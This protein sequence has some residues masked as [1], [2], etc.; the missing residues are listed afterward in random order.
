MF[1]RMNAVR[2]IGV[3]VLVMWGFA[4]G[5]CAHFEGQSLES[6][7]ELRRQAADDRAQTAREEGYQRMSDD[8][9]NR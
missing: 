9:A 8:A 2:R 5:G 7:R 4:L 1:S 3:F 6:T